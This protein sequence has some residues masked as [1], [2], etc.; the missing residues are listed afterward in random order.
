MAKK[1]GSK[2]RSART[3][4]YVTKKYGQPHKSTTVKEKK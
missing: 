4:R 2:Y 3:G 1:G